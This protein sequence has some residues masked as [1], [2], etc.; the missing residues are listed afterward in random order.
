MILT[1]KKIQSLIKKTQKQCEIKAASKP[2][3][4]EVVEAEIEESKEALD[5]FREMKKLPYSS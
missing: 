4:Q 5:M 3:K 1:D 2:K